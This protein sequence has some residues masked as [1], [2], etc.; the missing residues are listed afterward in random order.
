MKH[1]TCKLL[2]LFLALVMILACAAPAL[3]LD[4]IDYDGDALTFQKADGS[5]FGMFAPQN[6]TSVYLVGDDVEIHYVPKNTTTYNGLHWGAIDDAELTKD[7]SFNADGS[8]DLIVSKDNCGKLL[9]VAPVK[10]D[11]G[12]TSAQYYLAIPAADKLEPKPTASVELAITN[13]TNMFKAVSASY[14]DG[15]L[16]VALS[17]T[18]YKNLF[19]GTYEEAVANGTDTSKWIAAYENAEGKL[20]FQIPVAEGETYLP[21]VAISQ[22]YYEKYLNGENPLARAFYPR[23]M[24]LDLTAKTLVTGDYDNTATLTVTNNVKM[25]KV[26]DTASLHTLGGPNS[27]SYKLDLLLTMGSDSFDK[28]FVGGKEAAAAATEGVADIDAD[29]VFTLSL[30]DV[31]DATFVASFHSVSKDTWYERQFTLDRAGKTLTIN[32]VGEPPATVTL[33]DGTYKLPEL[34][35][36]LSMFNHFVTDSGLLVVDGDTA[37]VRFITDG[38]TKSIQKYTKIALGKSSELLTE[39]VNKYQTELPQGVTVIEGVLQPKAAETD[40]D[41]YLFEIPLPKADV[42][43]LL[44]DSADDDIYIILWNKNGAEA[45]NNVP[46]WYKPDNDNYLTLGTLGEKENGGGSGGGESGGGESG[47]TVYPDGVYY[48]VPITIERASTGGTWHNTAL[49]TCTVYVEDGALFVDFTMVR[50]ERDKAP[51]YVWAETSAGRVDSVIDEA[52]LTCSFQ[53]L[54]VPNLGSV[55][56]SMMT[57]AMSSDYVVDYV[58]YI[59]DSAI[60][61]GGGSGSGEKKTETTTTV[62]NED[63]SVTETTVKAD[64][65]KVETTTAVYGSV[66]VVKTGADGKVT[67]A[68]AKISAKAVSAADGKPVKLP[69][70]LP[71]ATPLTVELPEGT[72]SAVVEIPVEKVSENSVVVLV[73]PD[74]TEEILPRTGM[75]EKGLTVR[76][77]GKATLKVVD[78]AQSFNDMP[79]DAKQAEAIRFVAARGLM[80]GVGQGNFAP[81][82]PMS[83]A[84]IATVLHRLAGKPA[85]SGAA[86][87]ADVAEGA[88]Y[89]EAVAWAANAGIT[90]GYGASFGVDDPVTGEQLIVMLWRMSGKPAA[91]AVESGASFWATEA[92]SWAVSV[93]LIGR[94]LTGANAGAPLSRAQVAEIMERYINLG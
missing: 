88:W 39:A 62:T 4:P 79:A 55:N 26:A 77:E 27:N 89:A 67:E 87:F 58:M 83:R 46:A 9:P 53:R 25:F 44:S 57:T 90:Q 42:E 17:G 28:A 80:N 85:V 40:P 6:G 14:A 5:A 34:S 66:A 29:K 56:V 21:V 93:G 19:K 91:A 81:T 20:E 73:R 51:E 41:Q 50:G 3:A 43:A 47:G 15:K 16:T 18:G 30:K 38:S 48:N 60:L 59:D 72:D 82:L 78:N 11:G 92:M 35:A 7:V 52:A 94:E 22:S 68:S 45:N 32:E 86:G 65:S 33:S 31:T 84:M 71:A 10:P 54:P 70:Q 12:T 63:G 24:E 23:Q 75:T 64:G 49:P 61:N 2:S 13:N 1:N 76:V 37:T 8:F 36:S 74:G 69:V